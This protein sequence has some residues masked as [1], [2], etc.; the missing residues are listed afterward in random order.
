MLLYAI[1]DRSQ[2]N[3]PL[4]D[5]IALLLEAGVDLLQIREKDLEGRALFDLVAAALALPNPQGTKILVNERTDVALAAG[6]HGVHLPA[7]SIAPARIRAIAPPGFLIGV[8]CHSVDGV[9]RAESEG[10]DFAVF[11]PVFDTPSKRVYGPPLGPEALARAAAGRRIP[12]LALGGIT[13]Q[14][15]RQC[16]AGGVA[17]ISLFQNATDPAE[18]VRA[19]RIDWKRP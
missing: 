15:F 17:G 14:N 18:I 5:R 12:V 9:Q 11:G 8:S 3:D 2:L 6:A 1:T 19:L 4:L 13:L 10:A 16:R 7:S